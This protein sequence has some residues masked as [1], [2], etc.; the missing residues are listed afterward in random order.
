MRE[1]FENVYEVTKMEVEQMEHR[2]KKYEIYLTLLRFTMFAFPY[3]T[4]GTAIASY[5]R[6]GFAIK[7]R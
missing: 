5:C 3:Y 1:W 6:V 4:P 7:A 2:I